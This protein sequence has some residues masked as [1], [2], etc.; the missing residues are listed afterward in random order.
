MAEPVLDGMHA[1]TPTTRRALA[2]CRG[3]FRMHAGKALAAALVVAALPTL[4]RV[5]GDHDRAWLIMIVAFIPPALLALLVVAVAAG[6]ARRR[7]LA[8]VAAAALALNVAWLAPFYAGEDPP[9]GGIPVVAMTANLLYGDADPA[10]VVKEVREQRV[11]LLALTELTPEAVLALGQAGLDTA[12]PYRHLRPDIDAHGSG[13][14]S[15]YPVTP[16]V[17]WDGIHRQPGARVQI[18]GRDVTVRV[19]HPFRTSMF[20]ARAYRADHGAL[21]ARLRDLG[22]AEP[23]IVLGDFNSTPN[24]DAMQRLFA[25][26][27]RD[28]GE[29]AGSGLA[30]TWRPRSWLPFLFQLD[31]VLISR[32]FGA[33]GTEVVEI[34]GTD[35]AGVVAS[36]IL[37]PR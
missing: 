34:G 23:A 4:V 27:W 36:L 28:A 24:H 10:A 37:G 18:G 6:L 29:S 5:V 31:H 11:D 3:A 25:D 22:T 26:G 17:D 7:V 30:R 19:V 12:L 21:R 9:A 16:L 8:G 13:L 1:Q 2:A 32:A 15:R 14:W 33:A 20:T 35:H